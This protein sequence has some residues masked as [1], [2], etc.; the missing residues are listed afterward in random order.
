MFLSLVNKLNRY[1]YDKYIHTS[2][3][4]LNKTTRTFPLLQ[5]VVRDA[6]G[7]DKLFVF[8]SLGGKTQNL[9]RYAKVWTHL[10]ES[11]LLHALTVLRG[12]NTEPEQVRKSV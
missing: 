12:Q 1:N 5:A 2:T 10:C 7:E 9:S 6:P 3:P 11:T 8:L 4:S